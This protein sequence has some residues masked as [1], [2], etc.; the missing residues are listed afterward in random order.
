M[1]RRVPPWAVTAL[2]GWAMLVAAASSTYGRTEL[3][4]DEGYTRLEATL[5]FQGS[6]D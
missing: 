1:D 3:S 5:P 2:L 4:L 6:P